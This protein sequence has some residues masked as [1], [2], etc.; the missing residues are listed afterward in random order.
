MEPVIRLDEHK[1]KTRKYETEVKELIGQLSDFSEYLR[2]KCWTLAASGKWREWDKSIPIGATITVDEEMLLGAG[3]KK[4]NALLYL[5][6]QVES[7]LD[8]VRKA[9]TCP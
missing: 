4:I 7:V 9:R 6:N 1:L 3:D 5:A 8:L 2:D